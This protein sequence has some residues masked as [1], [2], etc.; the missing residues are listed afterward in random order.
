LPRMC[1]EHLVDTHVRSPFTRRP[2][3]H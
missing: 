1:P 3:E 2:A